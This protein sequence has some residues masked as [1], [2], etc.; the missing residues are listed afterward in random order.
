[1][2]QC[3]EIYARNQY[4]RSY[5]VNLHKFK[6]EVNDDNQRSPNDRILHILQ[7]RVTA[8]AFLH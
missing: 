7:A 4:V 2:Q 8:F 5:G 1:M 3:I 6:M